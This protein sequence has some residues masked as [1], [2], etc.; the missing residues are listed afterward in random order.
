MVICTLIYL[1]TVITCNPARTNLANGQVVCS[2]SNE[3]GSV[4]K[5]TCDSG[6]GL[7]N[8]SLASTTCIDD[9]N[10]DANGEW[11]STPPTCSGI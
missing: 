4:C 2:N 5:Y 8:T 3:L 1:V 7:S 11:N 9:G 6:Y 10:N